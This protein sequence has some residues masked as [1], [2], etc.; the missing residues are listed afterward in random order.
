MLTQL[1]DLNCDTV[2]RAQVFCFVCCFGIQ[3]ESI[4]VWHAQCIAEEER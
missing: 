3:N 1:I 4:E 2:S